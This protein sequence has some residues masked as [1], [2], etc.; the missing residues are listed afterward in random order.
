MVASNEPVGA[1]HPLLNKG[2]YIRQGCPIQHVGLFIG[3]NDLI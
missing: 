3:A 1:R 2:M